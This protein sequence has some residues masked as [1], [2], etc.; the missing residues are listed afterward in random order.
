M[1]RYQIKQKIGSGGMATVHLARD[2]MLGRDVAV[3]LLHAHLLE[4]PSSIKRFRNEAQVAATLSHDNIIKVFD[5][6]EEGGH[7]YIVMEYISGTTL[8]ELVRTCGQLPNTVL[9][10]LAF[11]VAS[12]LAAAHSKGVL[13]RDIKPANI[14]ID[15]TGQ[16]RIADFGIA[17]CI[18]NESITLT[19]SLVGSPEFLSPEQARGASL[20]ERTDIFSMGSTLYFC[21]TGAAPFT[22]ENPHAA[23]RSILELDPAPAMTRNPRCL[24]V[25]SD[26]IMRCLTKDPAS[27]PGAAECARAIQEICATHGLPND[28]SNVQKFRADAQHFSREE[29]AW[30][31]E[32]YRLQ[33]QTRFEKKKMAE[34]V[35]FLS[36]ARA[37]GTL[38]ERDEKFL[39][40][41][42]LTIPKAILLFLLVVAVAG[43]GFLVLSR[44]PKPPDASAA[45]IKDAAPAGQTAVNLDLATV[46][47]KEMR[48]SAAPGDTGRILR[49]VKMKKETPI[50]KAPAAPALQQSGISRPDTM[51]ARPAAADSIIAPPGNAAPGW[52]SVKSNPPWA[53]IYIDNAQK[54]FTPKNAIFEV[55]AGQH[56]LAVRKSGYADV[57]KSIVVSSDDTLAIM[58]ELPVL[59]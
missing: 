19:G 31:F 49:N 30:L 5:Y 3:K 4:R 43:S 36:Q 18:N 38:S 50:Q 54:G 10:S 25:L 52:V 58:V 40:P 2:T 23:M 22:Q 37:F 26:L 27:R 42:L 6:G 59:K 45:A 51:S 47:S 14:L 28:R 24:Q 13:H 57:N 12:G 11:Q 39:R 32:H 7:Q 29:S 1:N 20:T 48:D 53:N 9:L 16:A 41:P 35:R 56:E 34:G 46:P 33:A 15:A 21:A 44:K 17:H 8:D 55:P